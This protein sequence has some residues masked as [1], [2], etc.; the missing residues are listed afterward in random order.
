MTEHVAQFLRYLTVERGASPHTLKSYRT[1]LKQ[2][3]DFLADQGIREPRRVDGRTIRVYLA[4]LHEAGLG[5]TSVARKLAAVR[6]CFAFMARRGIVER[7]PAR[8]IGTRRQPQKLVSFL[9][10]DETW[11]LLNAPTGGSARDL[12]DRAILEM[13]YASGVRVA[14]LCGLNLAALDL[15][16]GTVRIMGKGGK[17][18]IVPVGQVALDAIKAYLAGRGREDGPLFRNRRGGR[19][20]VRSV[21]RIV[22]GR[23]RA[24]GLARRVS[25]HT[26]RHTFATHLLDAGAD[27]RLIQDLLGHSRLTTTQKYTHVSA[28]HLMKV[29]DA[30]HPRAQPE[31]IP[32][33]SSASPG[34]TGG[35]R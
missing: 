8:E 20:T 17:E 1:D 15:W 4:R 24:A 35:R 16:A 13:L 23:A 26:L 32:V 33:P 21:H 30:A 29:Y 7:N 18:R 12:R 10:V 14:E 11:V 19:L 3:T 31:G 28:D 25:P 5:R 34:G 6:S 2:F 9:P 22:R 27:L